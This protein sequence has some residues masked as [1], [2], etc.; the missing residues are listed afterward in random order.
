V[1]LVGDGPRALQATR[2]TAYDVVLVATELPSL[3]GVEV[4]RVLRQRED[5]LASTR[6]GA[7]AAHAPPRLPI[8][9]FTAATEPDDLRL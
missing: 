7:A 1:T 8:V 5:G 6:S 9:A 4:T 3:S 2:E